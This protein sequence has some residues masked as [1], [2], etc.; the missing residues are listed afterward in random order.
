[1]LQDA[2]ARERRAEFD[3]TEA[4]VSIEEAACLPNHAVRE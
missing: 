4:G 3:S 2:D 1:L